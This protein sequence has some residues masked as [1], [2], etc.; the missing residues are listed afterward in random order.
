MEYL[1][2]ATSVVDMIYE[3]KEKKCLK[4]F[5]NLCAAGKIPVFL[6]NLYVRKTILNPLYRNGEPDSPLLL[7]HGIFHCD[8]SY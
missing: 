3:C 4:E 7:K 6:S 8:R 1:N 5:C 2:G